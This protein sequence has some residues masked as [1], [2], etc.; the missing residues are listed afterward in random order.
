MKLGTYLINLFAIIIGVMI[1]PSFQ[2]SDESE[3]KIQELNNTL[4]KANHTYPSENIYLQLDRPSYWANDNIWFK[5]YLESKIDSSNIYVELISP[6]GKIIQKN[7]YLAVDGLAYG[8]IH[9]PDTISSGVYHIRSYTNWMRNF[10]ESSFFHQNIIIWNTNDKIINSEKEALSANEINLQFFPEGGTL[11]SGVKSKMGFK[12][13]DENG[14]GVQANGTILDDK[15]VFV[16]FFKSLYK[17]MGSFE[18]IPEE[19]RKYIAIVAVN[20]KETKFD[21]PKPEQ[22]GVSLSIETKVPEELRITISEKSDEN[23][24]AASQYYILGQTRGHLLF[25]R[26][27]SLKDGR[28][29]L[30]ID[31]NK[32]PT[33]VLQLTLFDA[34]LIPRC[35]RLV[36]INHN[37]FI[38]LNLQTNKRTYST[39]EEVLVNIVSLF[40]DSIP[41]IWNLSLT[42]VSTENQLK[43]EEYPN[44]ILTQF[45][46]KSDLKG[47]IE[48]PA[49]YFKDNN[50]ETLAALDNLMLSQGWRRFS[51]QAIINNELKPLNF[52][53][54]SSITVKGT[55]STKFLEKPLSNTEVTLIF[56][57]QA[58]KFYQQTTDSMGRF[59]F[60]GLY[61]FDKTSAMI[62]AQKE[63]GK[64]NIWLEIDNN[65]ATLPEVEQLPLDYLLKNEEKVNTTFDISIRDSSIIQ[66]K[67]HISD[68]ILL[69]DIDIFGRGTEKKFEEALMIIPNPDRTAIINHD[70]DVA[71]SVFDYIQFN[72]P[73]LIIDDS[74]SEPVISFGSNSGPVLVLLDGIPVDIDWIEDMSF[75]EFD[76]IDAQRFAPMYGIKGNNG[77]IN[78]TTRRG[79]KNTEVLL[80]AG[81]K[82]FSLQGYAIIREFYS[83]NYNNAS[84][85]IE[86]TDFRSTLYW[87]PNIWTNQNGKANVCFYNSDQPGEVEIIVEGFTTDG[88]LCRGT[89]SYVVNH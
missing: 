77:V 61:F 42:A 52:E 45:L 68:T 87:N 4:I 80:P 71:A 17:G 39:R 38:H 41:T 51:W 63:N 33:G 12:A 40:K 67:W 36:F 44:N 79:V 84:H 1:L 85:A 7:I 64:K 62:Q 15:G 35:E 83:P 81:V 58:Y 5:A 2:P 56:D 13:V 89:Y 31:K 21:L 86:K 53:H 50:K 11:L 48:E 34:N 55:V 14:V 29:G 23:Q 75:S 28:Y 69:N 43:M 27:I 60:D 9:L 18:F 46:L 70:V 82:R 8:D 20:G 73:G 74:G 6:T 32:I 10:D 3:S 25:S 26:E 78:F 49:Y 37:D 24:T 57:Q 76:R 16:T 72:M 66:H 22:N 65:S 30:K 88:R 47:R 54:Q 19:N 59:S